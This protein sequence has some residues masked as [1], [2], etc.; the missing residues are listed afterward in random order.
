[1]GRGSVGPEMVGRRR[2]LEME[3]VLGRGSTGEALEVELWRENHFVGREKKLERLDEGDAERVI[4]GSEGDE[5][6]LLDGR[7]GC[8]CCCCCSW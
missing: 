5:R 6:A 8:C 7:F 1:M 4:E 2:E 3:L